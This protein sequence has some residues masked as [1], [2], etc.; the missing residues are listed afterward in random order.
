M[1]NFAVQLK[2]MFNI[3]TKKRQ[4]LTQILTIS[5]NQETIL[6]SKMDAEEISAFF[7]AMND[8]KQHL[9]DE[10]IKTDD[11][12]QDMFNGI[13]DV[14]EE[15]A[16]E[17]K[18]EIGGL[19]AEIKWLIEMDTKIRLQEEKNK[20]HLARLNKNVKK[21]DLSQAAKDYIIRQYGKN[22]RGEF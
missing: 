13:K 14:F 17:H 19:Q 16:K 6:V 11:M 4:A 7:V 3:L 9:I 21:I 20:S 18:E 22:A 2:V 15:R 1:D 12:F 5:E 8:E 10:V